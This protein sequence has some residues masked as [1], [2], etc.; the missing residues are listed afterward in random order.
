MEQEEQNPEIKMEEPK[1]L[2]FFELISE[3]T[4]Y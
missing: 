4:L 3:E 2:F 1:E